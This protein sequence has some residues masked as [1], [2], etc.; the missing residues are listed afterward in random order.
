MR[1]QIFPALAT[2]GPIPGY[3]FLNQLRVVRK[4][5]IYRVAALV[6]CFRV[7]KD[8]ILPT[9]QNVNDSQSIRFGITRSCGNVACQSSY[10]LM[11]EVF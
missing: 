6:Q 2:A 8:H 1:H 4:L 10:F 7:F 3:S 11:S 9:Q 5:A